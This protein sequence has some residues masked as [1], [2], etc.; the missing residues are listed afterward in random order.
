MNPGRKTNVPAFTLVEL[1]VVIAIIAILAAWLLPAL[2]RAKDRAKTINCLGNLKQLATCV[3]LYST[4]YG[5]CLVPNNSVAFIGSLGSP[6]GADTQGISWCLD[7]IN[8]PAANQINPSNIVNGLLFQYNSSLA[9][10]H[11][12]ADLSTLESS[13]GQPLPGLRWRSYNMSQS[14]NGYPSYV[15]PGLTGGDLQLWTSIPSWSKFSSIRHPIPSELFV[16]IDENEATI[17]D[18]QFGNPL[19]PPL[20]GALADTWWDM[21]ANRHNQGANLS[22]AD[23]HVERWGWRAP[24]TCDVFSQE[25]TPDQMQ[26]YQ[27]IENAMKQLT[28]N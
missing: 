25:V 27:R 17:Y 3:H 5:D 23:G 15:P 20:P 7:G 16:F 11:C 19:Q 10:Y 26:D 21:P 6:A 28:D 2:S 22:F 9:I 13:D 1:L 24:M 12:P 8:G 4:D 18:G 14:V